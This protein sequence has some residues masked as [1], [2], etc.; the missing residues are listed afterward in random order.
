MQVR[1]KSLLISAVLAFSAIAPTAAMAKSGYMTCQMTD[2]DKRRVFTTP[3]EFR[4][5][6]ADTDKAFARYIALYQAEKIPYITQD[7]S[8]IQ[9]ICDWEADKGVAM[10]KTTN[11]M[12]HFLQQGY[13]VHSDISMPDPFVP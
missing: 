12:I 7:L 13:L 4:A 3:N 11:Y 8:H 10:T 1:H 5:D 9:G 2:S 6:S